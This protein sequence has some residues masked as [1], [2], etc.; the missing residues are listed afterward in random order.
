MKRLRYVY[1]KNFRA[2]LNKEY[3]GNLYSLT[4]FLRSLTAIEKEREKLEGRFNNILKTWNTDIKFN[5]QLQG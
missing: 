4:C 2:D 3:F 1:F 5:G